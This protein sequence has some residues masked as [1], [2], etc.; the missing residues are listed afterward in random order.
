[1]IQLN[2]DDGSCVIYSLEKDQLMRFVS[3][4][5]TSVP[6]D[7]IT[8]DVAG[9]SHSSQPLLLIQNFPI[10]RSLK[11]RGK[12]LLP[13]FAQEYFTNYVEE[14][15]RL[16]DQ[17]EKCQLVVSRLLANF[18]LGLANPKVQLKLF[19]LLCSRT[20]KIFKQLKE[21]G[22][23]QYYDTKASTTDRLNEVLFGSGPSPDKA[24]I[25]QVDSADSPGRLSR[26]DSP[27]PRLSTEGHLEW[28][29][30]IEENIKLLNLMLGDPAFVNDLAS[31]LFDRDESK[32]KVKA[33][34]TLTSTL[35][36]MMDLANDIISFHGILLLKNLFVIVNVQREIAV[37]DN[38]NLP[39]ELWKKLIQIEMAQ[40]H[41]E[42]VH[43]SQFKTFFILQTLNE[44]FKVDMSNKTSNSTSELV[45][46]SAL[47]K[48][49]ISL[50]HRYMNKSISYQTS[51]LLLKYLKSTTAKGRLAVDQA[52]FHNHTVI[53]LKHFLL[54][55]EKSSSE[56]K[57]LSA[58]IIWHLVNENPLALN[59]LTRLIPKYIV[60]KLRGGLNLQNVAKWKS[61]DWF[62]AIEL[63]SEEFEL[64]KSEG[65]SSPVVLLTTLR[66]YI[67]SYYQSWNRIPE[68]V[69]SKV[70]D[71]VVHHRASHLSDI[72]KTV[73]TRH[74][75]EEFELNYS[76][77]LDQIHVGKYIISE[78]YNHTALQPEL[79]TD[80]AEPEAFY[81]EIKNFYINQR[82]ASS[83]VEAL[84]IMSLM[85]N[86]YHLRKIELMPYFIQE[87][88]QTD[89]LALQYHLIQY[90]C[91]LTDCKE[92]Y[93]RYHNL[94]EFYKSKLY[95][96]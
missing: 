34:R 86:K 84:K 95:L 64:S 90:F 62:N 12:G 25:F 61:Q 76:K 8:E 44:T 31:T 20:I 5:Y 69:L 29:R 14:Y 75:F 23:A 52:F 45:L 53:L 16:G 96:Q 57:K 6:H 7:K 93:T 67:T 40:G 43:F 65:M 11:I 10:N 15:Y 60:R 2:F 71:N 42:S 79:L 83:K 3:E 39:R 51:S 70:F 1:M 38:L 22:V 92:P 81:Q 59:F 48:I 66:E 82:S 17:E 88:A 4:I 50:L 18:Y 46:N 56:Q 89:D 36:E 63:L 41:E 73:Q 80:I 68:D 37:D 55:L 87:L 49:L 21:S 58:E 72:V 77:L 35:Y 32:L 28:L 91:T 19:Y 33:L 24:Q 47:G 78:L 26:G 85:Y 74:N 54:T 94:N 27:E 9:K 30:I 13:T